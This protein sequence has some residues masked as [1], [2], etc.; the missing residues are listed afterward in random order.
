MCTNYYFVCTVIIL[1]NFQQINLLFYLLPIYIFYL[2][3]YCIA[4]CS[5]SFYATYLIYHI[6]PFSTLFLNS[7]IA[8]FVFDLYYYPWTNKSWPQIDLSHWCKLYGARN[9]WQVIHAASY[10]PYLYPASLKYQIKPLV[11]AS[12]YIIAKNPILL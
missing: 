4:L 12:S 11:T 2:P 10:L 3:Y 8:T 6:F 1:Y 9:I 5:F 7:P